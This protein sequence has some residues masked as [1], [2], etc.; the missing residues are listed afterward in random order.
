MIRVAFAE[1][2]G[3][4]VPTTSGIGPPQVP[5]IQAS[6]SPQLR[7][8]I[9]WSHGWPSA[10]L[11]GV[12]AAVLMF[13]PL[14]AYGLG[15]LAAGAFAAVFYRRRAP[16]ANLTAPAGAW[17]G[18]LSGMIG[19][20]IFVVFVAVVTLF[21][22]T[23]RLRSILLEAVAQSAARTSDPQTLQT[24]EY[25]KTSPGLAVILVLGLIFLFLLFTLFSALGGALGA[26]WLHRR[27][28]S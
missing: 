6:S 14:G 9:D 17:L 23:Q 8:R 15:M 25:F 13:F 19:F 12:I 21:S 26:A 11:A 1:P 28:R 2:S 24:F 16:Y 4:A 3:F 22:G 5:S 20:G 10:I 18:A 7:S 27:S